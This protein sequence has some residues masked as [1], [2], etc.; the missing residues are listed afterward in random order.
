MDVVG[1]GNPQHP[2]VWLD[3]RSDVRH[4]LADMSAAATF[5]MRDLSR[6]TARIFAA[7]RKFGHVQIKTRTGEV[8]TIAR[9]ASA[10]S[11]R[12]KEDPAAEFVRL[13][14]ERAKKFREMGYVPPKPGEWDEE[15]FNRII[16]GEE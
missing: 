16:A 15:R 1:D 3:S 12:K 2:E 7:V 11:R 14:E 8:F 9:E 10:G 4:S 13:S 6:E 5:T